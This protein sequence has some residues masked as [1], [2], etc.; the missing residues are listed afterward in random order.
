MPAKAIKTLIIGGGQA[1]LAA[2]WHLSKLG[3]EHTVLERIAERWRSGRW[4]Y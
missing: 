1:E 2:N 4:D 3:G